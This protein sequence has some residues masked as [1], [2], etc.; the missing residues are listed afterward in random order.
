VS[1]RG[2]V[3]QRGGRVDLIVLTDDAAG[4]WPR[5]F[6]QIREA[7]GGSRRQRSVR[8][9]AATRAADRCVTSRPLVAFTKP[10]RPAL[11]R[12]CASCS[13]G[14]RELFTD[15]HSLP[16]SAVMPLLR[17]ESNH[18]D[19]NVYARNNR[20]DTSSPGHRPALEQGGG[21]LRR[22]DI[23]SSWFRDGFAS[24][25][26]RQSTRPARRGR[27]RGRRSSQA[28]GVGALRTAAA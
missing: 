8:S 14:C 21:G 9:P 23:C 1:G 3:P 28:E 15:A 16:T 12:A 24:N 13:T 11:V 27:R 26:R 18:L 22:E 19:R 10:C 2:G 17:T 7:I 6:R 5:A 25:S 20:D 4:G